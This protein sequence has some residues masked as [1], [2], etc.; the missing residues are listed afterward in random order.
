MT[1]KIEN[2]TPATTDATTEAPADAQPTPAKVGEPI[3]AETA[4]NENSNREAAKYRMAAREAEGERDNLQTQL[5]ALQR[6]HISG[7]VTEIGYKPDGVLA[8]TDLEAFL[9]DDGTVNLENVER[10]TRDTAEKFGLKKMG[11]IP[12]PDPFI[13]GDGLGNHTQG[14]QWGE[15]FKPKGYDA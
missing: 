1:E 12:L 8:S 11:R 6:Q 10:I 15:A 13:G 3:S 5:I 4:P 14:N 9:N 2:P 7:I